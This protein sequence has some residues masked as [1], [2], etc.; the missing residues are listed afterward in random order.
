MK[1]IKKQVLD[2]LRIYKDAN[3]WYLYADGYE[4][5]MQVMGISK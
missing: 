3:N 5:A 4:Y 1:I 2:I